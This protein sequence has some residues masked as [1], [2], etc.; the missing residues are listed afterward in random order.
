M[1]KLTAV[2]ASKLIV[3]SVTGDNTNHVEISA[4]HG[5]CTAFK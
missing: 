3:H 5:K 1:C 4:P 2:S